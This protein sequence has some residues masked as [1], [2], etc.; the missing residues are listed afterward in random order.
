M[1]PCTI[2]QYCVNLLSILAYSS[3]MYAVACIHACQYGRVMHVH[4][5]TFCKSGHIIA[6]SY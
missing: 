5:S 4:K 2:S 1:V 3:I 6:G